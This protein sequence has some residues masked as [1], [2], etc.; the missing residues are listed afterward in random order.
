MITK[1]LLN[2]EGTRA[3]VFIRKKGYKKLLTVDGGTIFKNTEIE[4]NYFVTDPDEIETLLGHINA[5]IH[6]QYN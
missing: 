5:R 6:K 4:D 3:Q 2:S 1:I